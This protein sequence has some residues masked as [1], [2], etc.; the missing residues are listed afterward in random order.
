MSEALPA[1]RPLDPASLDAVIDAFYAKVRGDPDLGPVFAAAVPDAEWPA[2]LARIRAFWSNVL[3]R[4]GAYGGNP[5]GVHARLEG[6]TP[7]LFGRWLALFAETAR[8]ILTE[9]DAAA[10][11]E[12]ALRIAESLQA[13]LFFRPDRTTPGVS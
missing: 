1:P 13:G 12:R 8:E 4:T 7:A 2:H 5:F 11:H 6:L 10:L 3:F 9:S